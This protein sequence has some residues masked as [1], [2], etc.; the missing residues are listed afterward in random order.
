VA[1]KALPFG[2]R[3]RIG[4][5]L[6]AFL[7]GPLDFVG[8][9]MWRKGTTLLGVALALGVVCTVLDVP[10][11]VGKAVGYGV[12]AIAMTTANYAY[13]LHVTTGGRSWNP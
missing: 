7:F 10:D 13:Y 1:Y 12:A 4:S 9:G 11:M 5:N 2:E 8:K 3:F 6:L